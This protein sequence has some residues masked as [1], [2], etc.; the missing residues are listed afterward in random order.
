MEPIEITTQLDGTVQVTSTNT[1]RTIEQGL[2]TC[3]LDDCFHRARFISFKTAT[4]F[5]YIDHSAQDDLQPFLVKQLHTSRWFGYNMARC[6]IPEQRLFTVNIYRATAEAKA[7]LLMHFS[8]IFLNTAKSDGTL[9]LTQTLEDLCFFTDNELFV[10]TVSHASV[11]LV[12]PPDQSFADALPTYGKWSYY[13]DNSM[14]I[15]LADFLIF[16]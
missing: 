7:V 8:E 15:K 3:F 16:E 14:Q 2:F 11:L 6:P 5:G 9:D 1:A 12:Y 10:G 4:W 13:N